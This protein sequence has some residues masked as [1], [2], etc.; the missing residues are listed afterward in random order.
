MVAFQVISHVALCIFRSLHS[1]DIA[2]LSGKSENKIFLLNNKLIVRRFE[3][4]I[5][6]N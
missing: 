5:H 2:S 6:R 1:N 4:A 3:K